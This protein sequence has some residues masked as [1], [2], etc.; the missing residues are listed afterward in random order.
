MCVFSC[1]A[2]LIFVRQYGNYSVQKYP[3]SLLDMWFECSSC[4]FSKLKVIHVSCLPN[5]VTDDLASWTNGE[6]FCISSQYL[7]K[8]NLLALYS[9][10]GRFCG[11]NLS[12]T[13]SI[14]RFS[15]SVRFSCSARRWFR[16]GSVELILSEHVMGYN[17][18]HGWSP[19]RW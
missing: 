18:Q 19:V 8:V 7:S 14:Q 2:T 10:C 17:I 12:T 1:R 9:C 6:A 15:R 3:C 5:W 11:S 4:F 13:P 16:I